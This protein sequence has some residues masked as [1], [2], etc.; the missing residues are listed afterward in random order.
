MKA[1][2]LIF[3]Q[4]DFPL[5]NSLL[6]PFLFSF[7]YF[8]KNDCKTLFS[9][10]FFIEFQA[11]FNDQ[12]HGQRSNPLPWT[13]VF[14]LCLKIWIVAL[15]FNLKIYIY[16]N[17]FWK[18]FSAFVS[19][20]GLLRFEI[21]V[22]LGLIMVVTSSWHI[23]LGFTWEHTSPWMFTYAFQYFF[24]NLNV[25]SAFHAS[26]DYVHLRVMKVWNSY[27][28]TMTYF[29]SLHHFFFFFLTY[30]FWNMD[31]PCRPSILSLWHMPLLSTL[32][33]L[34]SSS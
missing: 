12:F 26:F 21:I 22:I 27:R 1:T 19:F 3:F 28:W 34:H 11:L 5:E 4:N 13:L 14:P 2:C 17:W 24:P 10:P 33:V 30:D 6:N 32:L 29:L 20:H 25:I 9:N 8:K 31:Y 18:P 7:T 15:F 23:W 16:L